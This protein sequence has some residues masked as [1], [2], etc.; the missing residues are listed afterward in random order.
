MRRLAQKVSVPKGYFTS[1]KRSSPRG[2]LNLEIVVVPAH[3]FEVFG[4][5][6]RV[7]GSWTVEGG[8]PE[9]LSTDRS[10]LR[11]KVAGVG[12]ASP[13]LFGV[14]TCGL[15]GVASIKKKKSE[16]ASIKS[17]AASVHPLEETSHRLV[18]RSFD[19]PMN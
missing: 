8:A 17:C 2:Q 3:S 9:G 19:T 11:R 6:A 16:V 18:K 4:G 15:A 7:S 13:T 10:Q 14:L 12:G 1:K 5:C